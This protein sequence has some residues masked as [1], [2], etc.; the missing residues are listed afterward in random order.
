MTP[1]TMNHRLRVAAKT[2]GRAQLN[3]EIGAGLPADTDCRAGDFSGQSGEDVAVDGTGNCSAERCATEKGA[4]LPV[5]GSVTPV[6]TTASSVRAR[7]ATS[8]V[9][10]RRP[11]A[12]HADVLMTAGREADAECLHRVNAG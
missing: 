2:R 8:E 11:A 12:G 6:L 5:T 1:S 4:F 3:R 10:R 7:S 9:D